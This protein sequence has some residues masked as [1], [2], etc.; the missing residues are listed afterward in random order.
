MEDKEK[1]RKRDRKFKDKVRHGGKRKELLDTNGFVCSQCGKEAK[2]FYIVAHH[3]T[4]DP[5][6][7]S[8]QELLCRSCHAKIHS[9]DRK[10]IPEELMSS[11]IHTSNSLDDAAKKLN[12]SRSTLYKKRI[13]SGLIWEI[14]QICGGKFKPKP[15][16]RQYCSIQCAEIGKTIKR[17]K[18]EIKYRERRKE[19]NKQYY[20]RNRERI[21][22]NF[23]SRLTDGGGDS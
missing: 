3:S 14:C 8:Q 13:K 10:H 19:F 7:H 12:L 16:L 1:K 11:T 5:T 23:A 2:S 18:R 15:Q 4:F 9:R 17:K 20:L 22:K 6:D 21:L